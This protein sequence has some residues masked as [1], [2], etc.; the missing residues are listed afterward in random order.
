MS[1]AKDKILLLL[2]NELDPSEQDIFKKQ[3]LQIP[4]LQ[5]EY[6]MQGEMDGLLKK[7]FDI[8]KAPGLKRQNKK[9]TKQWFLSAAAI[10]LVLSA[11]IAINKNEP[12][13]YMKWDDGFSTEVLLI[14]CELDNLALAVSDDFSFETNLL[15]IEYD[16]N[17]LESK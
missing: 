13:N 7:C 2:K 11:V 8:K 5:E 12:D 3:L 4:D 15:I 14:D 17:E 1:Y 10:L 6:K 16:L 9:T